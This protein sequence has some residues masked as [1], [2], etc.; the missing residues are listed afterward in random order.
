MVLGNFILPSRHI[1]LKAQSGIKY[2][3]LLQSKR[4]LLLIPNF[5]ANKTQ[6]SPEFLTISNK[7]SH[8]FLL[9]IITR[10][11]YFPIN[12]SAILPLSC[13]I[14]LYSAISPE[15]INPEAGRKKFSLKIY[16]AAEGVGVEPTDGYTPSW[17]SKPFSLPHESPSK[18]L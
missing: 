13:Q 17:F 3:P 5:S 8:C 18:G 9:D 12:N 1:F 15:N 16:Y 14:Y 11:S 2:F 4:I 6:F 10:L 7:K